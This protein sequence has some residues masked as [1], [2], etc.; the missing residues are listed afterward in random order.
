MFRLALIA[1][2][3]SAKN[4]PMCAL[5][6]ETVAR[7]V[8]STV[9]APRLQSQPDDVPN[10]NPKKRKKTASTHRVVDV[11]AGG[12]EKRLNNSGPKSTA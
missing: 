1:N 11:P 3:A 2:V 10:T 7:A 8:S 9:W 4:I 6:R 12:K 5:E